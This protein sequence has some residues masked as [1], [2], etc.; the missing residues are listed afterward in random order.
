MCHGL[1]VR[2]RLGLPHSDKG[3]H[4]TLGDF[5]HC[6]L[7]G[8]T[9]IAHRGSCN[10]TPVS[11][12][13]WLQRQQ[14]HSPT[15]LT[16]DR[17]L[18]LIEQIIGGYQH[19]FSLQPGAREPAPKGALQAKSGVFPHS[20]GGRVSEVRLHPAPDE[21]SDSPP[22][23]CTPAL[24]VSPPSALEAAARVLPLPAQLQA[25]SAALP[26]PSSAL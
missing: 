4:V 14:C 23:L 17:M 10:Q 1:V 18:M 11:G 20:S 15:C 2:L 12:L 19:A 16:S 25:T 8:P 7:A 22:L 5:Q 9:T 26:Q 6:F 13:Q 21:R 3:M 24:P